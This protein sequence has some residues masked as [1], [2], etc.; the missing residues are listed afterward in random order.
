MCSN[1]TALSTCWR[2]CRADRSAV[3]HAAVAKLSNSEPQ[4]VANICALTQALLQARPKGVKGTGMSGYMLS[5]HVTSTQGP[6]YAVSLPSVQQ[7]LQARN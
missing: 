2:P 5:L 6:G 7:T 3:V 1:Y 4:I